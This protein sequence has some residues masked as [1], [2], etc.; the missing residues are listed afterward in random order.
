MNSIDRVAVCSRSFSR[1]P[2]LRKELLEN[3]E[4]VTFNDSGL[5]FD[6]KTLISFLQNHT[7]AIT[8]LEIIDDEL[9]SYLPKLKVISKYGVGLDMID[10][11]AMCR[12]GM[13]LGWTAGVNSRSVSELTL[14]LALGLLHRMVESNREIVEGNWRQLTG[15]MLSGRIVGI[16]GC[17]HIGKSLV[18][19]LQPFHCKIIV[20]DILYYPEFY[21]EFDIKPVSIDELLIKSDIVTLHLPLDNST[22]NILSRERLSLMKRTAILINTARGGLVDEIA[23]KSALI[24]NRL[25]AAAFDVFYE[26]PPGDLELVKLPN[27]VATS[28]IGG[29][30][31]EAILAMGRAAIVG[32]DINKIPHEMLP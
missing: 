10:L 29:S 2:I 17:G 31:E 3:Y 1:N 8:G 14:G 28:H 9:L 21:K 15:G 24:E 25:S 30:T 23:L 11:Q 32:L 4:Y 7:K 27:F 19:L 18:K 5:R 12:Y 16:I 26:E 20:N 6:R 22:I 13:R